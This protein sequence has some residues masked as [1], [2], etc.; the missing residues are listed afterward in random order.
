MRLNDGT[1]LAMF[2]SSLG[3]ETIKGGKVTQRYGRIQMMWIRA[4]KPHPELI[5]AIKEDTDNQSRLLEVTKLKCRH[6]EL[7]IAGLKE[8][9]ASNRQLDNRLI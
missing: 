3:I 2:C 6:A 1:P 4:H 7:M 8:L 9:L 5:K